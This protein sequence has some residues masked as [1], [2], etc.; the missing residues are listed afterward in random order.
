MNYSM[1]APL[2]Y[3]V[4]FGY[5]RQNASGTVFGNPQEVAIGRLS[6]HLIS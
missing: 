3:P 4:V 5:F 1:T 2:H 6:I